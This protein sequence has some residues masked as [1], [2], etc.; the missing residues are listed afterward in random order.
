MHV[1]A[2]P[3]KESWQRVVKP[4]NGKKK[5]KRKGHYY[6]SPLVYVD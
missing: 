6:Q 4:G 5:K 1:H 2:D 3:G